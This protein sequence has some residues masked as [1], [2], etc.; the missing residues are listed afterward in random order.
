MG[1]GGWA[2]LRED[3]NSAK[4]KAYDKDRTSLD[5]RNNAKPAEET[6]VVFSVSR[7]RTKYVLVH[8]KLGLFE[9][10]WSV[11]PLPTVNGGS[12]RLPLST[13]ILTK[14]LQ[15]RTCTLGDSLF[16]IFLKDP[17]GTR[18]SV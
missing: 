4:A 11:A 1:C 10:T 5:V 8:S 12:L 9:E 7:A 3:N 17:L 14:Q 2:I 6:G 13:H 16:G 15:I 18:L